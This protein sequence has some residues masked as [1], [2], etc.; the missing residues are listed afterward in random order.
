MDKEVNIE[1]HIKLTKRKCKTSHL[2]GQ[3]AETEELGAGRKSWGIFQLC[4]LKAGC[5]WLSGTTVSLFGDLR[6][7]SFSEVITRTKI[8]EQH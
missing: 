4:I 2:Y 6:L 7:Y 5:G 3:T 1:K 8:S